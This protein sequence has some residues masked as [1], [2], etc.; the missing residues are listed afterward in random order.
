MK[1]I[2]NLPKNETMEMTVSR[3]TTVEEVL[4]KV[5]DRYKNPIYLSIVNNAYRALTHKLTHDS[6]IEFLDI[7][8]P[9]AWHTY[10]NS[11]V[12]V[13]LKAVHDV[14]GKNAKI[15]IHN[16]L[17]RG[18]YTTFEQD[19]DKKDIKAINKRMKEIVALDLPIRKIHKS[20]DEA[21][22]LAKEYKY[23]EAECLIRSLPNLKNVEIYN[24]ED[25]TEIFYSE[26]VPSTGYLK[27]FELHPYKKNSAILRYPHT[28]D[29]NALSK[30]SDQK[31]LYNAFKEANEWAD[32]LHIQYVSELNEMINNNKMNDIYHLQEALH[33][34]RISDIADQI[35]KSKKRIVLICGPSSSGKTTFANR[36]CIQLRVNGIEP[37]YLG[38]DDYFKEANE[39]AIDENGEIDYESINAV[40]TKLFISDLKSLLKGKLV[41]LPTFDFVNET[42]VY[43]KRKTRISSNQVIVIEGIHSLNK[44][45]T[46]GID[47]NE[48]FKIYLSPFTPINID[49]YNRISTTDARFLRRLVRDYKFRGRSAIDTI[50]AWPKVRA[51]E[52]V[53][54]FPFHPEANVFF[55]SNCIYELSV[56]KKYAEPL[57]KE[58]TRD[59]KEYAEAQRMLSFLRFF[60]AANNDEDIVNNSIIKEFIGGST[61]VH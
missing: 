57:L 22:N 50:S 40:D 24:L 46:K 59:H 41:D 20:K 17:N 43:G 56:L 35:T 55:N 34:K 6:K 29:P 51:G 28:S 42:K 44:E 11:L 61:I 36:L 52:E 18:L 1:I 9:A 30:Y 3:N 48:K 10:Q 5:K 14:L 13:Y 19:V 37:L 60:E 23:K 21:L 54:I 58:V 16:S 8:N 7:N 49:R 45:L 39:K 4:N 53:N 31:L 47:E 25:E 2:I 15:I 12:L 27:L 26:L 38:T 33:E 32:L